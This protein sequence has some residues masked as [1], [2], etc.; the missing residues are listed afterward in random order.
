MTIPL[1]WWYKG[2]SRVSQH[3]HNIFG[4]LPSLNRARTF[5]ICIAKGAKEGEHGKRN[6]NGTNEL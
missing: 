2:V 6:G 4:P 5:L 1:R 3:V